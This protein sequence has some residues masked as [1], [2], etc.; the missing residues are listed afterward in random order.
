M[1]LVRVMPEVLGRWQLTEQ[2]KMQ[3]IIYLSYLEIKIKHFGSN[4]FKTAYYQ[5]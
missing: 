4:S 3:L 2:N 1:F 5:Y